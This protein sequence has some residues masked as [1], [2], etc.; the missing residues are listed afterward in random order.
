MY[1]GSSF[2]E[3]SLTTACPR[4]ASVV[5]LSDTAQ[6]CRMTKEVWDKLIAEPKRYKS[7]TEEKMIQLL[8]H[9]VL[10]KIPQFEPLLFSQKQRL[11]DSMVRVDYNK[12]RYISRQGNA[13]GSLYIIT[14]GECQITLENDDHTERE[15]SV[16]KPG[17]FFGEKS[18]F[19]FNRRRSNNIIAIDQVKCLRLNRFNF[20]NLIE[21]INAKNILG[22][23]LNTDLKKNPLYY[24]RRISGL[25]IFGRKEENR[26]MNIF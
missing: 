17:D 23:R 20:F 24:K 13:C 8:C 18:L 5:V 21:S 11:L 9:N 6:C 19:D 7:E 14:S 16:L 15:I 26:L 22:L 12:G 3:N 10:N 1:T 2:G 4:T 25:N